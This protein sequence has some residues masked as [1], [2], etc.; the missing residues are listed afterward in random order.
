MARYLESRGEL[1]RIITPVPHARTER[2]G[3][4][5][6][7]TSS[8]TPI[9]AWNY[10]VQR[11]GAPAVQAPSQLAVSVAFD[12]VA[13][14]MLG[15][16]DLFN[17]WSSMALTSMRAARR[18]GVPA[19]LTTGSAHAVTQTE[20]LAEEQRR[21]GPDA[22]LDASAACRADGGGV[23][24]SGRDRCA[25]AVGGRFVSAARRSGVEAVPRAVGRHPDHGAGGSH[26]NA[27]GLRASCSS[28]GARSGRA[29]RICWTR[30]AGCEAARRCGWSARRMRSCFGGRAGC[31]RGASPW[32]RRRRQS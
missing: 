1:E 26:A 3:V 21:F 7:R 8:L 27:P 20:L 25:V 13:S 32:A 15:S 22:P 10:G 23:C 28:V 19:V 18:R 30:F 31:R 6:E 5:R 14:R 12:A 29:C 17:G 24:G 2:F 9:G 16:C 11:F 4:S